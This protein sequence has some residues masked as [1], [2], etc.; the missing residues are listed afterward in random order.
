MIAIPEVFIGM[1]RTLCTLG[2][3]AGLS[4]LLFAGSAAPP[5]QKQQP[6]KPAAPAAETDP[7]KSPP[8]SE[9]KGIIDHSYKEIASPLALLGDA[10]KWVDEKVS[11]SATFVAFSPYA[12]D[13][14]AAMRPSKDYIAFLVQRPDVP[15]HV[16]PLSELKLIYPRKKADEV[17]ELESGDTILVKGK[18]FSAA[19]GDPWVD[20]DDIVL[21]RKSPENEAKNKK[22]G[23]KSKNSDLE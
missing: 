10:E 7:A 1:K 13:Y 16:I 11:F 8:K 3:V 22:S 6:E 12:L 23:K 21:L 20:V 5:A 2:L 14:K 19:L 15:Q 4:G 17:M 9:A 18:V